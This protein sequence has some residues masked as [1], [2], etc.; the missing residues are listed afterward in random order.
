MLRFKV[1]R[2]Q[3]SIDS[4]METQVKDGLPAKD[5]LPRE[6]IRTTTMDVLRL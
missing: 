3:L 5:G 1:E 2:K 4:R 6:I